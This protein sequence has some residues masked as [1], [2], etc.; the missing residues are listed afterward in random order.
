MI[1]CGSDCFNGM[2]WIILK[3]WMEFGLMFS[4]YENTQ[5]LRG[6]AM[7]FNGLFLNISSC[8]TK[9]VYI[10]LRH[11]GLQLFP[12]LKKIISK[13]ALWFSKCP[14]LLFY[15]YNGCILL[16]HWPEYVVGGLKTSCRVL[17]CSVD[18]LPWR[19]H[20]KLLSLAWA[21]CLQLFSHCKIQI[22]PTALECSILTSLPRDFLW[23]AVH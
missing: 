18:M 16:L 15:W 10:H 9:V 5:Y 3:I 4:L 17:L 8:V 21:L 2:L 6:K 19:C 14:P 23:G 20:E 13:C 12:A 7:W 22:F 11:F 1:L